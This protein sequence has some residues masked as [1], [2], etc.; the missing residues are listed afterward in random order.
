M[1]VRFRKSVRI[2][3]GVRLNFSKSGVST[4]FGGHGFTTTVGKRG[5]RVT[6]GIPGTGISYSA[7]V[8]GGSRSGARTSQ[9]GPSRSQVAA[10]KAIRD[11]A[12]YVGQ[13]Q[14]KF[15]VAITDAGE[16][17]FV[18]GD[19]AIIE[20]KQLIALLKKHPT[21]REN[22]I[23]YEA[24]ARERSLD[25]A[26]RLREET[27]A[28]L[29]IH[30]HAP[31]I[32]SSSEYEDALAKL[33]PQRYVREEYG[34]Q[35]PSEQEVR[36][37]LEGEAERS[38]SALLPWKKKRLVREWVD[39]RF[40]GELAAERSAWES[41]KR[42]FDLEQ[43]EVERRENTRFDEEFEGEKRRLEGALAGDEAYVE[44]WVSGWLESCELPVQI[45]VAFDYRRDS[46]TLMIDLDLPEIEDLPTTTTSQLASG[47]YREK[48]KT[49]KQ[50]KEEYVRCVLG[51]LVFIAA[52][53]FSASPA[54]GHVV[55]S[56]YTQRRNR[57]G[58]I[59]D[60]YIVSVNFERDKLASMDYSNVEPMETILQ[61]ENRMN[62]TPGNMFR[63][64]KPFE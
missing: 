49:Q 57:A 61:F 58:D 12:E 22:R 11:I 31:A 33:K 3:K 50:L 35:I 44:S 16:I 20:D 45:D 47:K 29:T 26:E 34:E 1:G 8:G 9:A 39:E 37:R 36:E 27:E 15:S 60:E 32:P 17:S 54:V 7:K 10:Q 64:I 5:T 4:S 63:T 55:I 6:V 30:E 13:D 53:M 19:G 46:G 21:Y 24:M 38:V 48:N 25:N 43:D 62:L 18:D 42:T 56:G 41:R 59:N 14:F 52:T 23:A 40:A 51:L 28:F 2:A